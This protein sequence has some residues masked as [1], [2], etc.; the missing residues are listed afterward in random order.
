MLVG[1]LKEFIRDQSGATAIEYGLLA[2]MIAVAAIASFAILGNSLIR[3][4]DNGAA[5]IMNTQA[6][7]I[8]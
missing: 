4:W 6:A 7:K 5:E 2:A 3:L 1:K 8:Q